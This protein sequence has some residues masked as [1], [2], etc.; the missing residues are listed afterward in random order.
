MNLVDLAIVLLLLTAAAHGISQGAAVQVFAFGGFW[1]GLWLGATVSPAVASAVASP[2]GKA[3]LSLF[4]LFAVAVIGGATGRIFGTRAWSALQRLRLGAADAAAGAVVAVAATLIAVWLMALMLS[5]G[6][7]RSVAAAV[8]DSAIVRE[9]VERLPP[10]PSVFGRLR[11]FID[12]T[13][14]PQVFASL[15]PAPAAPVEV[16]SD[17]QVAAAVEAAGAST[18]RITGLGCGGVQTGSGFVAAPGLV[19]TNAHVVA[20]IDRPSVQDG[21]GTHAATPVLFDPALDV[22]VLRTSGLAGPP[23]AVFEGIVDR[24]TGGAVLGFPGGGGFT[25]GPAAVLRRFE[26]V[27]RDIYGR[28]LTRR[29]VYQ[30]QANVRQGNSGGPFV[31]PEGTVLGVI[32][33]AST[34]DANVGYALTS[35]QVIPSIDAARGRTQAVD[36]G[37]C[38]K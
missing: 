5:A 31:N 14:F 11:T 26:A 35:A 17:P 4:A 6:P 28:D 12:T 36:T 13:P 25:A 33:A 15:E 2:A 9:L 19:V 34:N 10:A 8:H 7:T 21:E 18:V 30:L 29:D 1:A 24:G 22:A 3:F 38:T 37:E 23:L 16:P 32:F 20:G 27:G